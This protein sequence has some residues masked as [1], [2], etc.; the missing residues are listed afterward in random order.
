MSIKR[1]VSRVGGSVAVIVPRDVA[2]SM[3]IGPGSPVR[4][5]LVGRQLVVEPADDT[6]D[7]AAFHRALSA[8]LRRRAPALRAL[9]AYDAGND[10]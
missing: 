8:V 3:G 2:E 1:R 4:L 10:S 6:A 9:A 5:S 7:D